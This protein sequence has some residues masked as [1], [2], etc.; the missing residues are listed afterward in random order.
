MPKVGSG[1][2]LDNTPKHLPEDNW[3]FELEDIIKWPLGSSTKM[4]PLRLLLQTKTT[5]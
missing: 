3:N 1:I 5:L 4:S 2:V